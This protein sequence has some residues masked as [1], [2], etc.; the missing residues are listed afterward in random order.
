[1]AWQMEMALPTAAI[2]YILRVY[3]RLLNCVE[4]ERN[5]GITTAAVM[6]KCMSFQVVDCCG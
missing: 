6:C 2:I 5:K 3:L 4:Q 1:M